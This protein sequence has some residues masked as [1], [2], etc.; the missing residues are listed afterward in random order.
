MARSFL[1]SALLWLGIV[2]AGVSAYAYFSFHQV[3]LS[4]E[5]DSL[6]QL[7]AQTAQLL[8]DDPKGGQGS[9]FWG[10]LVAPGTLVRWVDAQGQVNVELTSDPDLTSRPA[11]FRNLSRPAVIERSS[12]RAYVMAPVFRGNSQTGVVE[13]GRRWT[14]L[15]SQ[16]KQFGYGLA[17][18]A[19]A[20][21]AL[22]AS[23]LAAAARL[24]RETSLEK[25]RRFLA[26]LFHELRTP[27]TVI[28]SYAGMMKRWAGSDVKLREEATEV[29]VS[30]AARL[31]RLATRLLSREGWSGVDDLPLHAVTYDLAGQLRGVAER[32]SE[33]FGRPIRVQTGV[34]DNRPPDVDGGAAPRQ[35]APPPSLRITGDREQL[36]QV[37]IILLDNAIKYSDDVIEIELSEQ[38]EDAE[39]VIRDYG[40]GI[41][42][43]E[44][45]YLFDRHYRGRSAR[46][47]RGGSGL[48]LSIAH[49]I[50]HRHGGT[51]RID[52]IQGKGTSVT[53]TLPKR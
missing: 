42:R 31:R 27:L 13:F 1:I 41:P 14:K 11:S 47:W 17:G 49:G 8:N 22:T 20:A 38:A 32:M 18:M 16:W 53:V 48:G 4:N 29:I 3:T 50:V 34:S 46:L 30:E 6:L 24:N 35:M 12:D 9:S 10:T 40:I 26:D 36:E 15:A 21:L 52:S 33:A 44:L 23:G 28:E 7:A 45:P 43:R 25:Q 37:W 51:I 2:L 5:T 39:V 19:A